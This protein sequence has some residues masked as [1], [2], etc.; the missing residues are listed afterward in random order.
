MNADALRARLAQAAG[1]GAVRTGEASGLRFAHG[2]APHAVVAPEKAE[3]AAG[4]LAAC[5]AEGWRTLCAGAG[6]WLPAGRPGAVDV[7]LTTERLTGPI[8]HSPVDLTAS[9]PA[10][11]PLHILQSACAAHRQHWP[12]DPPADHSTTAGAVAAMASAGPARFAAGTPRD[13]VLGL[14]LVTGDGRVLRLGGR[15]VKNVAGYDLVRLVVGSAGRLGLITRLELRLRSLPEDAVTAVC[16]ATE[17]DPLIEL[18]ARARDAWPDAIELVS[19]PV[20]HA[21]LDA[22]HWTLLIRCAGNRAFV[23]EART[24]LAALQPGRC[25]ILAAAEADSVWSRLRAAEIETS[26]L[27]RL[28]GPPA[29]LA[30]SLA[31]ALEITGDDAGRWR[32]ACHAGDGI[33]RVWRSDPI[34]VDRAARL[35]RAIESARAKCSAARIRVTMPVVPPS[36]S[37]DFEPVPMSEAARRLTRAVQ[38]VFDPAGILDP[39][40]PAPH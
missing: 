34:D 39:S 19:P 7:V 6:T 13:H 24:R 30:T 1:A 14:E 40:G 29:A 37:R 27:V 26:A 33:V 23:A 8:G 32:L 10:G 3:H 28:A 21:V 25:R 36:M 17:P 4:V 35:A 11:T 12:V 20:A 2:A 22:L 5:S 18:A 9:V 38:N 15:V 16:V 31:A